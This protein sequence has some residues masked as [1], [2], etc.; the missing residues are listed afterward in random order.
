MASLQ[1]SIAWGVA[2]SLN[3]LIIPKELLASTPSC[4]GGPI[5]ECL[6]VERNLVPARLLGL[7]KLPGNDM[8][9]CNTFHSRIPTLPR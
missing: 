7:Y 3:C 6:K 9:R 4:D 2:L 1:S 5:D 8:G